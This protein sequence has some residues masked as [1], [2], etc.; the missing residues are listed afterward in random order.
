M[1]KN[2]DNYCKSIFEDLDYPLASE[3]ER[4][5]FQDI[6]NWKGKIVFMTPQ[7]FL[8]LASFLPHNMVNQDSLNKL[9]DRF[10]NQLPV[11]PL[12]LIVDMANKKVEGHEGRHRAKAAISKGIEKVPV[13]V[14][15][16]SCYTRT[17]KWTDQQHKDVEDVENFS[18]Q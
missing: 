14:V 1:T 12:V 8:Q 17:P 7:K 5:C 15:T 9:Q 13:L 4:T 16:G 3:K 6:E 18:P 11:D 10:A 2:F